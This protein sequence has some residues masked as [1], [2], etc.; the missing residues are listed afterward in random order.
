MLVSLLGLMVAIAWYFA[1]ENF[2]AVVRT[3]NFMA[4]LIFCGT[5]FIP[6]PKGENHYMRILVVEDTPQD[7]ELLKTNVLDNFHCHI[8]NE[9]NGEW[10]LEKVLTNQYD[11]VFLDLSLPKVDGRTIL[12]QMRHF[13][14]RSTPIVFTG[15]PEAIKSDPAFQDV[16]VL[17]KTEFGTVSEAMVSAGIPKKEP[18]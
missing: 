18:K 15:S 9:W 11:V 2:L 13:N 5:S 14:I 10:A 4:A 16:I 8:E 17:N 12:K 3:A 6:N 1:D 7:F